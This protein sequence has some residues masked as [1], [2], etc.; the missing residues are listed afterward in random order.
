MAQAKKKAEMPKEEKVQA[1]IIARI[2][3]IEKPTD[4]Q[5]AESKAARTELG[6]LRF[7]RIANK[8]IPKALKMIEGIEGLGK[9]SYTRTEE[10]NKAIVKALQDAVERVELALTGGK[11]SSGGF[12]LPGAEPQK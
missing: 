5:K 11:A 9:A 10:Q 1:D 4:T 6:R 2:A 7:L 12:V 8:R 3:K